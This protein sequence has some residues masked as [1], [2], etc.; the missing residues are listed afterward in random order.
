MRVSCCFLLGVLSVTAVTGFTTQRPTTL[1]S[2]RAQS[3]NVVSP[4]HLTD[5]ATALHPDSLHLLSHAFSSHLLADTA[6]AAADDGGW[7]QSYLNLFKSTLL[8]VHSTIDPPL[9]SIGFTQTWGVSIALF[10]ASECDSYCLVDVRFVDCSS[11]C[12][13]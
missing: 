2:T 5:L 11:S 1:Q 3:L 10:T 7:W 12:A 9:R 8:A 4:E 13:S 6:T